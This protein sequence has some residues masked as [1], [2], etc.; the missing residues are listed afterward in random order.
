MSTSRQLKL[1][2]IDRLHLHEIYIEW[3]DANLEFGHLG[4]TT[5]S[6]PSHVGRSYIGPITTSTP[7]LKKSLV[8]SASS[9]LGPI[10]IVT[11]APSYN[12]INNSIILMKRK[13]E[14]KKKEIQ[15]FDERICF[16]T[17]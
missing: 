2:I 4:P 17:A 5:T 8:R 16:I 3:H 1:E 10:F 12:S 6:S 7:V 9:H 14:R 11:L 13:K 15:C